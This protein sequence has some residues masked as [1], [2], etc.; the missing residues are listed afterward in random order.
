MPLAT[1]V[2]VADGTRKAAVIRPERVNF[3]MAE[4]PAA[5]PAIVES[6]LY[7]GTMIRYVTRAG[8]QRIDV[9][10]VNRGGAPRQPGESAYLTWDPKDF[11]LVEEPAKKKAGGRAR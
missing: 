8:N 11:L 3:G 9:V 5:I 1:E 6:V 7:G 10:A 2:P 4:D